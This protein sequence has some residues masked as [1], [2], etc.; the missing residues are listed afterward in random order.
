VPLPGLAAYFMSDDSARLIESVR[1]AE[2][3][4]YRRAW[5]NDAHTLW[6][7]VYVHMTRVLDATSTISVGS[8]V[9][10]L[11]T[12][13]F[14]VAASAHGT[15]A[16][17][18]PGRVVL[19]LGR[20]DAAVHTMGLAPMST[21]EFGRQTRLV[22]RLLRGEP[23]SAAGRE[24]R[25]RWLQGDPVPIMIGA[26]GPRNLFLAGGVADIVQLEVG[27]TEAAVRWGIDRV[28]AGAEAAGRDP[29]EVEISIVCAMWIED[30]LDEARARCRWAAASA[31]NHIEEVMKRE[32]HNMPQEMTS[33]VERRRATKHEHSYDTHL[34][35][36]EAEGAFLTDE[37][38]D[39]FAIAGDSERCRERLQ[40][41]ARIGVAEVA[42]GF[43]N[44]ELDQ[45]RR[46]GAEVIAR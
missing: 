18:H 5:L 29:A 36:S 3:A 4:G 28:R 7:D 39:N 25:I 1:A 37:L 15:L 13:H 20:G 27:V 21:G 14:S 38:I 34:G 31:A 16:Q 26:T 10:N 11:V 17:I 44:A 6:Q 2:R 45:M 9:T 43:L 42:S 19:G 22:R 40:A 32:G 23:V 35:G 33:V 46:V 24:F 12:R 8:G 41:L 30:E